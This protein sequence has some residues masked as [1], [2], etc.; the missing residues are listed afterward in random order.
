MEE[1][2]KHSLSVGIICSP[3]MIYQIQQQFYKDLKL[4]EEWEE[5]RLLIF[6]CDPSHMT[7][8]T[9]HTHE[10]HLWVL[11]MYEIIRSISEIVR[12]DTASFPNSHKKLAEVKKKFT[13]IRIPLAKFQ[14]VGDKKSKTFAYPVLN[15]TYGI[16]W[17][18]EDQS[19]Y[20]RQ[21]L[22]KETK[23]LLRLL[24]IDITNRSAT[25]SSEST[26]I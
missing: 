24:H 8:L 26:S 20:I 9:I 22:A 14:K 11:G 5:L 19:F 1:I 21:Q 12:K 17:Q 6:Q 15:S 2:I 3:H 18:L 23:E 4:N 7:Q 10:S 13:A 16:G 25:G